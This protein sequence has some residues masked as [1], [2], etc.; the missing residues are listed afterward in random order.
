MIGRVFYTAALFFFF[1]IH[2]GLWT[3]CSFHTTK[4]D[5]T[6]G[7]SVSACLVRWRA[8]ILRD[9]PRGQRQHLPVVGFSPAFQAAVP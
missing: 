7:R 4:T 1:N 3:P 6:D 8:L 5:G 2:D 9:L